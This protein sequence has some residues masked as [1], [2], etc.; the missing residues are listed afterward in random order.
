M[1]AQLPP[2]H[3]AGSACLQTAKL[4]DWPCLISAFFKVRPRITACGP[5]V[6][7]ETCKLLP[8]KLANGHARHV[9]RPAGQRMAV[10]LLQVYIYMALPSCLY[11]CSGGMLQRPVCSMVI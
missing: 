7:D 2:E 1:A 3:V 11:S 10:V 4:G 8:W 6:R 5:G 9:A